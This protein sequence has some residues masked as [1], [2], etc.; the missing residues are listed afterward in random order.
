M[1]LLFVSAMLAVRFAVSYES[2][3]FVS[4]MLAVSFA[5]NYD[6]RKAFSRTDGRYGPAQEICY[7]KE[8]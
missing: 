8:K 1:V 2:G 5:V 7:T 3:L 4:A 6:S